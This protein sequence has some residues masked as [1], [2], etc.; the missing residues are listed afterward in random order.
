MSQLGGFCVNDVLQGGNPAKVAVNNLSLGIQRGEVFGLL[1]P[2]GAGKTT[3]IQMMIGFSTP[4][5]GV[6]PDRACA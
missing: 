5:S 6:P 1:G 3:A 2:N 4:T